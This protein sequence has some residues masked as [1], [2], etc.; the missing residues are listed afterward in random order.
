MLNT[1]SSTNTISTTG[2]VEQVK[3]RHH[4]PVMYCTAW[5]AHAYKHA[6]VQIYGKED[7]EMC[8]GTEQH[9]KYTLGEWREEMVKE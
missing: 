4:K 9:Q 3:A 8:R 2:L 7:G 6:N 5:A 1:N